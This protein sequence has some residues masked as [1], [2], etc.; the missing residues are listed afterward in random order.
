MVVL[1][2]ILGAVL[3]AVLGYAARQRAELREHAERIEMLLL[4]NEGLRCENRA[5]EGSLNM[6]LAEIDRVA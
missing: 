2:I 5:H 4:E 3:M 1:S 6:L